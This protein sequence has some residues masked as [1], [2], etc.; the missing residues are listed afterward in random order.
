MREAREIWKNS[1]SSEQE[2]LKQEN[3]L[4]RSQL[5]TRW[6]AGRGGR[7]GMDSGPQGLFDHLA[8]QQQQ[9]Q[10]QNAQCLASHSAAGGPTLLSDQPDIKQQGTRECAQ[11]SECGFQA[12]VSSSQIC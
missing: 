9:R 2:K 12:V 11:N 8:V 5:Q 4:I 1:S 6:G 10:M 7:F 3:T